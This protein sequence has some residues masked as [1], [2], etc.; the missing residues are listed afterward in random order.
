MGND[1]RELMARAAQGDA[2]AFARVA[3]RYRGHL[4]RVG[5]LRLGCAEAAEDVAQET[6]FRAM[7]QVRHYRGAANPLTWLHSIAVHVCHRWL[8]RRKRHVFTSDASLFDRDRGPAPFGVVPRVLR[9]ETERLLRRALGSLT[10]PQRDAF[11]LHYLD[12]LP[13]EAVARILNTSTQGVRALCHRARRTLRLRL[14][15]HFLFTA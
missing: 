2:S 3:A 4:E 1:D 13:H 5:F 7:L 15:R 8:E 11:V 14:A 10:G 12:E 9:R 6:L